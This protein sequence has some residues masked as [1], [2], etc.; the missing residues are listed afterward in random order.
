MS[1]KNTAP[2]KAPETKAD[3]TKK[4]EYECLTRIDSDVRYEAGDVI[5]L[6]DS[7][8]EQLL[9]VKAVKAPD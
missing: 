1:S 6:T 5:E 8:A 7:Q 4:R 9:E 2:A 3:K